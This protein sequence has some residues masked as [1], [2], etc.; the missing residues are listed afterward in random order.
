MCAKMDIPDNSRDTSQENN[1]SSIS[2]EYSKAKNNSVD[3]NVPIIQSERSLYTENN[4]ETSIW[5]TLD[6][7]H[8]NNMEKIKQLDLNRNKFAFIIYRPIPSVVICLSIGTFMLA[9]GITMALLGR[10][11][12][13]V[14]IQYKES[15]T[16]PIKFEVKQTLYSPVYMYYRI[17]NFY[18][19]HKKYTNDSIYNIS[20]Q[21]RCLAVNKLRELVDF[22]C[23]NGKNTLYPGDEGDK[24]CDMTTMDMDIFNRDIYPCGISSATIMTDEYRI[25]TNSDLKNCYEHTMPVD[26]RDSDIFRN[27]FEYDENKLVWIDPMNIRLRR[28][29]VSAF[30]PNFQV[31]YGI[32]EQDIP[33]GTYYLNVKNNT[34]PSN[35]W[36]AEKGIALVTTTIFGGKST[37][38]MIIIFTIG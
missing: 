18:A 38:F 17:T 12:D 31:L 5:S 30:G 3:I 27:L 26:S 32:I 34:W 2:N 1:D 19:S 33:A 22:R 28:W 29:N 14:F 37:P 16:D 23:F 7:C 25:C 6:S 4:G 20:D 36:N 9:I 21:N 11:I 24:I 35:E 10:T 8:I 15:E 13:T